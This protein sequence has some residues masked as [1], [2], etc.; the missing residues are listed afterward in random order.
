MF[1]NEALS[2]TAYVKNIL[3]TSSYMI[4]FRRGQRPDLV[5]VGLQCLVSNPISSSNLQNHEYQVELHRETKQRDLF[6]SPNSKVLELP[7]GSQAHRSLD[8]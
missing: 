8:L 4:Q 6:L 7:L 3:I 5:H 1:Q 2:Q